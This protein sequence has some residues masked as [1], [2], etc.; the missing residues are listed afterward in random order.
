MTIR[1]QRLMTLF[2][3]SRMAVPVLLV[4]TAVAAAAGFALD[5]SDCQEARS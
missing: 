5:A 2:L 1:Y 4:L 3:R